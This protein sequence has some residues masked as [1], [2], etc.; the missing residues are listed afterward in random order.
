MCELPAKS[1]FSR[2]H[3]AGLALG[4]LALVPLRGAF[5]ASKQIEALAV[6]CIDFRFI[7]RQ[8]A[9]LDTNL[10]LTQ[11]YDLVASAGASLAA[12]SEM[13]PASVTQFWNQVA[14]ARRFH[15]IKKIVFIDHMGCGAYGTEFNVPTPDDERRRHM[16]VMR[17]AKA[18]LQQKHHDLGSAFYLTEENGTI[19]PVLI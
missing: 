12:V 8:V 11:N 3:F 13:F 18:L 17:E 16:V 1:G 19:N 9:Y 6:T 14:I 7:T 4:G 2:R 5:G 15:A 10:R